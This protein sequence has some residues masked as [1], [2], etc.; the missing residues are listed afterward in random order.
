MTKLAIESLHSRLIKFVFNYRILFAYI[1]TMSYICL[2]YYV[3]KED[4]AQQ[5]QQ[6]INQLENKIKN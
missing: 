5:Q 4:L 2:H 3:S 6:N 1:M